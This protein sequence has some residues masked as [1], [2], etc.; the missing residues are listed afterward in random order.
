VYTFIG[1]WGTCNKIENLLDDKKTW[2]KV[3]FDAA[4]NEAKFAEIKKTSPF[5][6]K[7]V[8]AVSYDNGGTSFYGD[9]FTF[10]N[11][12]GGV[13]I[14]SSIVKNVICSK[15]WAIHDLDEY[16]L[17]FEKLRIFGNGDAGDVE[18]FW[19]GCGRPGVKSPESAQRRQ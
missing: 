7:M 19:M 9:I 2:A 15:G 16:M 3:V 10:A 18:I 5:A 13:D 14:A 6:D 4:K 8:I 17:T 12:N 1:A 11:A